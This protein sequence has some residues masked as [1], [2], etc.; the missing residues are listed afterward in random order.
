MNIHLQ[1]IL[2]KMDRASMYSSLESRVPYLS[3]KLVEIAANTSWKDCI[4]SN[5]GKDNVKKIL[6]NYTGNEFVYATKKGFDIPIHQWINGNLKKNIESTISSMPSELKQYFD[7]TQ[8]NKM[9][10]N[11]FSKKEQNGNMIWAVYVLINW[12]NEHRNSYKLSQA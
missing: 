1:R 9:L 12:Y 4:I 7:L 2:L 6:A 8:L 5:Q 3:N 11:H 10:Q